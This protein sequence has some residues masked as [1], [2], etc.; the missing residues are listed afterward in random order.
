MFETIAHKLAGFLPDY[1][2][3]L[4]SVL[5]D[6]VPWIVARVRL[7]SDTWQAITFWAASFALYLLTHFLM[8]GRA[9]D[10]FT[11]V[12]ATFLSNGLHLILTSLAFV[13]V[14][15]VFG[16]VLTLPAVMVSA[17]YCW[18]AVIPIQIVLT[19][20]MFGA[21]RFVSEDAFVII[22]N[23]LN[24]CSDFSATMGLG[25]EVSRAIQSAGG[26]EWG[27]LSLYGALFLI[28]A[29]VSI[30]YGAA[31]LRILQH[32]A[33]AGAV[34]FAVMSIFGVVLWGLAGSVSAVVDVMLLKD[35]SAC[36]PL[37]EAL[38]A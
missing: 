34:R 27:V 9:V 5:R 15:R 32:L 24:G 11:Y 29:A 17:A 23:T 8:F 2:A 30:Y 25:D 3:T 26:V 7:Q 18:G 35:Q 22:A 19:I 20:V 4:W 28:F 31:F 38:N 14:W 1:G 21:V 12:V 16:R 13:L 36:L 33:P 10:P 37:A 6:P